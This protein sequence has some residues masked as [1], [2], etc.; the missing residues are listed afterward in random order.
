[1]QEYYVEITDM[2]GGERN[3]SWVTRLKV[4]AKSRHG[5]L[6]KLS[7]HTG[8]NWRNDYGDYYVSNSGVTGAIVEKWDDESH[9][10]YKHDVI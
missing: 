4:L 5:A 1:M 8:V 2:F 6:C 3:Y 10:G 9:G 7:K